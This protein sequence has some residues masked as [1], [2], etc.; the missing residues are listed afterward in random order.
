MRFLLPTVLNLGNDSDPV[1]DFP[2]QVAIEALVPSSTETG[3]NNSPTRKR[4]TPNFELYNLP[5][6]KCQRR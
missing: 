4:S 5:R 6:N 1:E 3:L 2:A